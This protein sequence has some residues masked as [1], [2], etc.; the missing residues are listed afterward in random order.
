MGVVSLEEAIQKTYGWGNRKRQFN[1]RQIGL[2]LQVL[3]AKG[4]IQPELGLL[5]AE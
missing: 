2:A 1:E 3:A 5:P 4:W